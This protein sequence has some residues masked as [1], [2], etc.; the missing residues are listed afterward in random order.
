[1]NSNR[2]EKTKKK[3]IIEKSIEQALGSTFIGLP[4]IFRTEKTCLKYMWIILFTLS[5]AASIFTI[6]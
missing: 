3:L 5:L 6:F 2:E 1:M 4:N